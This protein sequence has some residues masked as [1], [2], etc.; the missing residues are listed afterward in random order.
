MKRV[1]IFLIIIFMAGCATIISGTTDEISFTSNADPVKVYIDGFKV[2]ETPLKVD[3]E[4]KAGE[5]RLVR[6]EKEGYET[7]EFKLRN[8]VDWIIVSDISS[9]IISGGIDVL[10]GAIMEYSPKQYHIEMVKK[11][12]AGSEMGSRQIKFASFVLIMSDDIQAN[13][14]AG[15]GPALEGLLELV[16]QGQSTYKFSVWLGENTQKL[17]S[18]KTPEELLTMLR[19]SGL[20]P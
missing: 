14:A 5:G 7:Q 18:A 3:V 17:L 19:S 6:F 1:A 13:L 2:G 10:S 16:G 9:V 11:A 12:D 20:T 8:K 15:S 4:K